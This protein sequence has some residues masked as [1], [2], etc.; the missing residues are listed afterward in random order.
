M[1]YIDS[2]VFLNAILNDESLGRESRKFLGKIEENEIKA[3]TSVLTFDEVAWIVKKNRNYET[4]L[5]AVKNLLDMPIEFIDANYEIICLSYDL[6]KKYQLKPRD[7]IHAAS[8]LSRNI[9]IIISEDS[10]FDDIK[11]IKRKNVVQF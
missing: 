3:S 4:S 2:T 6:M 10:D 5:V 1:I 9:K 7:A 8:A 11:E